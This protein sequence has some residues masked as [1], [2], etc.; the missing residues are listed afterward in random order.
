MIEGRTR[1]HSS[2]M[3]DGPGRQSRPRL[4]T[5]TCLSQERDADVSDLT[6]HPPSR[7][8]RFESSD[9]GQAHPQEELPLKQR[10]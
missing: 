10:V 1:D 8:I 9:A 3:S 2:Q 5:R 7:A 6:L 4:K